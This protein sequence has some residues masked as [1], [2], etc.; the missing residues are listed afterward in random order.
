MDAIERIE[1][2]KVKGSMS[3]I[4]GFQAM[5]VLSPPTGEK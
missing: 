4:Y 2:V 1:M 3:S 5:A